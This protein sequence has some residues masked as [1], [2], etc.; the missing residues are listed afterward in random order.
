MQYLFSPLDQ[1]FDLGFGGIA[2]SF[3]YAADA[4]LAP[5]SNSPDLNPHLPANFLYRHAIELYL[6][7][8]I[9]IFHR[10]LKL[11]YGDFAHDGEPHVPVGL[12]WKPM[13][14][15]HRLSV[16]HQYFR[17]LFVSNADYLATNTVV[18]WDLPPELESNIALID[19][20]DATSTF[21]RYPVTKHQEQDKNKSIIRADS[22][23]NIVNRMG[24][25]QPPQKML[26]TV[27]DA[28]EVVQAFH[29]DDSLI[30]KTT[31]VLKATAEILYGCHAAMRGTI[32]GGQ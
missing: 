12:R 18:N 2:N 27:N 11:P 10:K 29:F 22:F 20:T 23:E 31:E 1:H 6:K 21:F 15:I 24:A 32:T 9:I 28:Q 16:L 13:Y 3:K 25:G 14:S 30:K 8:G 26:L 17:Q 19:A 7:S 5:E 4:V